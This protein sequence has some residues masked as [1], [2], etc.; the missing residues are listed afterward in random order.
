MLILSAKEYFRHKNVINAKNMTQ[1]Q[2]LKDEKA[3]SAGFHQLVEQSTCSALMLFLRCS[4]A[5]NRFFSCSECM[6]T[7]PQ[8]ALPAQGLI[9]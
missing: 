2:N 1:T 9:P 3:L 4:H 7:N 8:V 5:V 6:L